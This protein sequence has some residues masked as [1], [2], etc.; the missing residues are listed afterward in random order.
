MNEKLLF[1]EK[2]RM[3]SILDNIG[4]G[5]ITTDTRG[6]IDSINVSAERLTGWTQEAAAGKRFEEVLSIIDINGGEPIDSPIAEVMKTGCVVGLKNHSAFVAKDGNKYYI[7][8]SCSPITDTAGTITG[9]F[10]VLKDITGQK[11]REDEII[12]TKESCLKMMESFPTPVWR[13]DCNGKCNYLNK[14]WLDF[15][16]MNLKEALG[17]K[18]LEAVHPEDRERCG[19]ISSDAINRRAPFEME[20]RMKRFDGEYRWVVSLGAPYYDHEKQFAG[21]I[22]T[23]YDITGRKIAEDGLSRYKI[24]SES[25]RDII[26]FVDLDGR[27][28]DVNEATLKAYGYTKDEMLSMNISQL[29]AEGSIT[30]EF[31]DKINHEGVFYETLHYRR[32]GSTF[33]VEISSQGAE[34]GGK[35]VLVS[36]I[37]DITERKEIEHAL[38]ESEQKYRS[39]FNVA[40]DGI[41]LHEIL[42]DDN[43][44]SRIV[45][46]NDITCKR[47]GYTREEL[48]N[49]HITQVN[50][51]DDKEFYRKVFNEIITKGQYTF[52]NIHVTKDGRDIPV[53]INAH[54]YQAN[55]KR[56][57]LSLARDM[58]ERRKAESALRESEE[59]FRQ[60]FHNSTD[61]IFVQEIP[62]GN[63][64]GR[65]VEVN[66][67]ACRM[68]GCSR[69]DFFNKAPADFDPGKDFEQLR[70]L[71]QN[72]FKQGHVTFERT[73]QT[74]D[75]R[76]IDLEINAHVFNLKNKQMMIEIARDITERKKAE[77]KIR[78][79]QE[80]YHSL[81]MNM[82]SSFTY[83]KAILDESGKLVDFEYMEVNNA[84]A[85][86]IGLKRED[87]IG[88]RFTDLYPQY[89]NSDAKI[90]E[91]FSRAAIHG[92]KVFIESYFSEI[93][94]RWYNMA[95]YSPEKYYFATISSDIHD[96]KTAQEE[97]E[98]A[99]EQAEIAN[100]AKSEFLANMSHEIRTPINGIV[101]M[102]DLTMLTELTY[103]QRDNLLT[104]KSC[105]NSLMKIIN[106][107]LDFSKMEAGKLQ[108]D[109]INFEIKALVEEVFKTHTPY[110]NEKGLELNYSF[111]S[112]IPQLLT[113]DPSR[114]K[115]ILNNLIGNA[116]KFTEQGE[117]N[118]S[119]KRDRVTEESIEL[120]FAVSDTGIGIS[121]EEK[122]RLFKTF[123]QV[124][125][126]ITRR[127]GGSGLGLAISKQLV[128]MMDGRMWVE[129]EK[130]KGSAFYF[131]IK[132]KTEGNKREAVVPQ[133]VENIA[134]R[135]ANILLVEDN[136]V[137]QAV[138][139]R[140][141]TKEGYRVDVA[142]DGLEALKLHSERE[143]DLI[144]MDIQMPNMDG[145][146]ATKRIREKEGPTKHTAIIALTAY[147]LQGD[148]ERFLSAG[149]DEYLAKPVNFEELY[150]I[151]EK[152]T[153]KKVNNLPVSGFK[154]DDEGNILLVETKKTG[155][156][157]QLNDIVSMI[158]A[159]IGRLTEHLGNSNLQQAEKNAHELRELCESAGEDE[160]KALAFQIELT[161]RRN[162]SSQAIRYTKVFEQE[163]KKIMDSNF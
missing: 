99:I 28:L 29:R 128:E 152:T 53:E 112:N 157:Y 52:D 109:H 133:S 123:S 5:V 87:I 96:R 146:E 9:V 140:M 120:K 151:I 46:V 10:V 100:K 82:F 141:L 35:R 18:W 68:F 32:D 147:A 134:S 159:N 38:R 132:F 56:Y 102:I 98:R 131:T 4:D 64:N 48:L 2:D 88:K 49:L 93:L 110:A 73:G 43:Y 135:E 17:I 62:E 142:N 89:K 37:R 162:S 11:N 101:G 34:V 94:G 3:A 69:E 12:R 54:Y 59:K 50:K 130:G 21:Y 47:L 20:H 106:D 33:P 66:D 127:F 60:L 8:A 25:T 65:L 145:V 155:V 91:I 75:G 154:V 15:T 121:E 114:L 115:Q 40:T 158:E 105:A 70:N 143:Y 163:F 118:I 39:L 55:G 67:T 26:H 144:L 78:K 79:S 129:S 97:L 58:S 136:G 92:E 103:E 116:V 150:K 139:T 85:E 27:I 7:S 71:M 1:L 6:K 111:S 113:G 42:N 63:I 36:I 160:L 156:R 24:L 44:F 119:V 81:F 124:D 122:E 137:N 77:E 61:A 31:L 126:S 76:K 57:I 86:S 83:N 45:E 19:R 51:S 107:I 117:V 16:G 41:Y 148:R 23:V 14:G 72:L 80:K 149:M 13:S 153:E 30:Q 125:G 22:G 90:F 108:I 104:A 161:C 84:F 138:I 95:V 74:S